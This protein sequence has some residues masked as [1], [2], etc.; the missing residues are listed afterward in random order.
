[1]VGLSCGI[2]RKEGRKEETNEGRKDRVGR[3]GGKNCA[4]EGDRE[5]A[6]VVKSL[7]PHSETLFLHLN[8][9]VRQELKNDNKGAISTL[10]RL[11]IEFALVFQE[12]K[13]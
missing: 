11:P 1:M 2:G 6:V 5:I 13:N 10:L 3:A 4:V 8:K 9:V 12:T 7:L